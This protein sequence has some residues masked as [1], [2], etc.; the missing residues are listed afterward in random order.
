MAKIRATGLPASQSHWHTLTMAHHS[1]DIRV[2]KTILRFLETLSFSQSCSFHLNC[3]DLEISAGMWPWL[4]SHCG[5]LEYRKPLFSRWCCL[6]LPESQTGPW[7]WTRAASGLER[8]LVILGETLNV[9]ATWN[10]VCYFIIKVCR[11]LENSPF[12]MFF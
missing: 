1:I 6:P 8:P 10:N 7:P 3:L 2:S 4:R 12:S 11:Y 5:L 9:T